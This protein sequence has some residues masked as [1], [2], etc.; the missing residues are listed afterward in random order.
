MPQR[1]KKERLKKHRYHR[2]RRKKHKTQL[3]ST[4]SNCKTNKQTFITYALA[5]S[6]AEQVRIIHA[7]KLYV[8]RCEFCRHLHLTL[9]QPKYRRKTNVKK[10]KRLHHD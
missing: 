9:R 10:G 8:Y 1:S 4:K 3:N 2:K 6:R 5:F 7:K